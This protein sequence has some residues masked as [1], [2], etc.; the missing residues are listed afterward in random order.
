MT[1]KQPI[2]PEILE[3]MSE[4]FP[5]IESVILFWETNRDTSIILTSQ[6]QLLHAKLNQN[7]PGVTKNNKS[8]VKI[9]HRLNEAKEKVFKILNI[10]N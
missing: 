10:T 6:N 7:F 2:I 1:R 8:L 9:G 4:N 5:H 3:E